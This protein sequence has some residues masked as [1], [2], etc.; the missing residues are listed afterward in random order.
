MARD[1]ALS[2]IRYR[3]YLDESGDHTSS[4]SEDIGRRYLGLI[5]TMVRVDQQRSFIDS[6][7][8]FK[9]E[10]L[11][12]DPD[13]PPILHR[14]DIL[15]RRGCFGVLLNEERRREFDAGLLRLLTA[16][17]YR[18]IAVVVDKFT[19]NQ[20]TYRMLTHPYHYCLHAMLER[21]CGYLD[22]VG[23]KG[24]VMA[25]SR[26]KAEDMALKLAYE[27]VLKRRGTRFMER[28]I[29]ERTLTSQEIKLKPKKA[30]I[31]GLQLSDILAHPLTR[32]VLAFYRRIEKREDA[33]STVVGRTVEA[34]YNC[35]LY[36]KRTRGYGRVLL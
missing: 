21:Y 35:H 36:S 14:E 2:E 15:H 22:H 17:P 30:N 27:S 18:I 3:L 8:S 31:A 5:G 34:K 28:S 24:D 29:A 10:H 19:H 1:L 9:R 26:G 20:K 33:F 32:D 7:E 16:A 13:D 11:S 12:F 25:E 4:D 23:G 6:I